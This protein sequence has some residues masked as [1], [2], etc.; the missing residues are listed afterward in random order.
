MH[1][2]GVLST[3]HNHTAAASLVWSGVMTYR[4]RIHIQPATYNKQ[5]INK[6]LYQCIIQLIERNAGAHMWMGKWRAYNIREEWSRLLCTCAAALALDLWWSQSSAHSQHQP[7]EWNPNDMCD[8]ISA[9]FISYRFNS[10]WHET[11]HYSQFQY[12][13]DQAVLHQ[14]NSTQDTHITAND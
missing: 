9:L 4:P 1:A 11:P 6:I 12:S 3:N 7:Y 2:R 14:I 8:A 13:T 10:T 5:F